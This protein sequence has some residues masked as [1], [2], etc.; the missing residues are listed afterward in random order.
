MRGTESISDARLLG[1]TEGR[2][3]RS[4]GLEAVVIAPSSSLST[5]GHSFYLLRAAVARREM[6]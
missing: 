1:P 5:V 4:A 6:T 2:D 3:P